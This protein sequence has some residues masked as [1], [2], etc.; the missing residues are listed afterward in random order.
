MVRFLISCALAILLTACG[1]STTQKSGSP[2]L[3]RFPVPK[4]NPIDRARFLEQFPLLNSDAE[5]AAFE[6]P[7]IEGYPLGVLIGM[8][9]SGEGTFCSASH[10][11]LGFVAT[12]AHCVE[13]WRTLG[14]D[15]YFLVYF[16]PSGLKKFTPVESF[17]YIGNPGSDDVAIL[18]IPKEAAIQ[19][20]TAGKAAKA[21]PVA[22]ATPETPQPA[23]L[24]FPIHI[25]AFDPF[26]PS[27]PDLMTKYKDRAGMIFK[28][29]T[30]QM[31][32]T[33]PTVVG[34]KVQPSGAIEHITINSAKAN[35]ALHF[36]V[37]QCDRPPVH[38]NSG[39]LVTVA[40]K[41]SEKIGVYHWGI[42]T[43]DGKEKY[44]YIEYTGTDGRTRFFH[45]AADWQD[46][47]GVGYLFEHFAGAHP[48]VLF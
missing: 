16:D 8:P 1:Q 19:W 5:E 40:E 32:R 23:P 44:D 28:P 34:S 31:T 21:V 6:H 24:T 29:R 35:P 9:D 4:P 3:P 42:G 45:E 20:Q 2:D 39:S 27:H 38:G 36:F 37:D 12:N 30:C 17:V 7:D 11:D 33:K 22:I 25:W 48:Q 18:K 26:S 10:L 46:M 13:Q 15:K 41:F 14:A 47:F 43:K